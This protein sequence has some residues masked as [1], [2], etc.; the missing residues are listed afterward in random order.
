MITIPLHAHMQVFILQL[1]G[2]KHWRLY[3][4]PTE[5]AQ[6]CSHDLS[7]EEIGEPTHDF[8]LEVRS[9]HTHVCFSLVWVKGQ[10]YVGVAKRL[11]MRLGDAYTV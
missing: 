8:I 5:L 11:G 9:L 6:S 10:I 1:E 2:C 3:R 7:Q 4:P